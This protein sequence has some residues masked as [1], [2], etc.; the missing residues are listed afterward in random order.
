MTASTIDLDRVLPAMDRGDL[1]QVCEQHH[2]RRL[3]LFGS[4]LAGTA[5]PDSDLDLLV[6]L[7]PGQAPG[8]MA[9]ATM[10]AGLSR[11]FGG[12][13]VDLRT[14]ADLSRYFRDEVA[15]HAVLIDAR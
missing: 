14:P 11:P 7:E 9:I 15:G 5:R 1:R 3:S 13:R 6:E 10:E 8:L 2:I 12:R 4:V